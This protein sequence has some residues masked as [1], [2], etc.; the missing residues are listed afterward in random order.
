ML[1]VDTKMKELQR[2][3]GRTQSMN[4]GSS[5]GISAAVSEDD[6]DLWNPALIATSAE[7]V[8]GELTSTKI[9]PR[10]K[11]ETHSYGSMRSVNSDPS[12]PIMTS[13]SR[14]GGFF[15]S[16]TA[17]IAPLDGYILH[18]ESH[19]SQSE[20]PD[21]D[22]RAPVVKL[23]TQQEHVAPEPSSFCSCF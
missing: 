19:I 10:N 3:N 11:T 7:S 6:Y 4:R 18:E 15:S 16:L 21:M 17:R 22:N 12:L 20:V 1:R 5:V 2:T 9:V 13:P 23:E 8:L 14:F